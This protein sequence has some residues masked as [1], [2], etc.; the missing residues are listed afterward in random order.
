M[1]LV[2]SGVSA[3]LEGFGMRAAIAPWGVWYPLLNSSDIPHSSPYRV[4]AKKAVYMARIP[5]EE[6]DRLKGRLGKKK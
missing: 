3:S 5:D 4:F 1:S 6:I 2:G